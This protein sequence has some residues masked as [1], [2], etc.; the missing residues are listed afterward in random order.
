MNEQQIIDPHGHG[1]SNPAMQYSG[2]H[3]YMNP[4]QGSPY[5]NNSYNPYGQPPMGL[6]RD[7]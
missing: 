7:G 2:P 1:L 3:G 4:A 5:P 6:P